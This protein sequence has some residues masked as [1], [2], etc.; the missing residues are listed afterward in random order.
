MFGKAV[1]NGTNFCNNF[2]GSFVVCLQVGNI[3]GL[4]QH[5]SEINK[6]L[7]EYEKKNVNKIAIDLD[8]F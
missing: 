8:D 3:L 5:Y 1:N 2:I 4:E 6:K 7:M